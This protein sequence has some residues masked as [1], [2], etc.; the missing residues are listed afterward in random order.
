[1]DSAQRRRMRTQA[2]WKVEANTSSPSSPPSI[3]RRRSLSSPA[4]LLVK[5]MAI[6][7]QLR[8]AFCRSIPSSQ[9]GAS[10][11]VIIAVFRA[12]T[13]SSVTSRGVQLEPWAEPNRI[14]FAMRLTRTVVLPLPAPARMS[15][16]PSV[17][18][19]ACRCISFRRPNCFSI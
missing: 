5:V 14:R 8:T 1:M 18:N 2:E 7:F 6:T 11:P 19:T 9:A 16:G 3:L 17:V 10:V 13:S 4:A 15:S 12:L